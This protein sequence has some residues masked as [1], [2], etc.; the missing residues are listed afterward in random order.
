MIPTDIESSV[1]WRVRHWTPDGTR[2]LVRHGSEAQVRSIAA[3]MGDKTIAV[4]A[5]AV[6]VGEWGDPATVEAEFMAGDE[7]DDGD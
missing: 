3:R 1:Q 5:R 6:V 2:E 7:D 4:E